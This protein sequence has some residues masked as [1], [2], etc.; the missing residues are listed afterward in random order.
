MLTFHAQMSSH[1]HGEELLP[2]FR[3]GCK[4]KHPVFI[5]HLWR[6]IEELLRSLISQG[7]ILS[8]SCGKKEFSPRLQDKIWAWERLLVHILTG[9]LIL[10]G[11]LVFSGGLTVIY[12]V[13]QCSIQ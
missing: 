5:L 7:K 9:G 8:R 4:M 2:S 10:R 3:H 6:K 1:N 11:G 13:I 12:V